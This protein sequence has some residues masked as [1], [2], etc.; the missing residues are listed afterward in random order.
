[1]LTADLARSR[2]Q[3]WTVTPLFIDP[4]DRQ[5]RETAQDLIQLFEAHPGEPKGELEETIDHSPS[6][7]PTTKSSKDWQSC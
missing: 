1:M 2:T 3:H 4:D 7:I 6:R 5:Y